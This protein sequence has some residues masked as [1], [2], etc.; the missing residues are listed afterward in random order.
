MTIRL[1]LIESDR[2]IEQKINDAIAKELNKLI[3][4]NSRR[5][6]DRV[7]IAIEGWIT[8]QPEIASLQSEGVVGELNAQ[9][10]LITGQGVLASLDIINAVLA[11]LEVKVRPID[12]RLRGGLDLNIQPVNFRTLL[13]LPSGFVITDSSPLHWL[14]WLLLEGTKTIV[15]G[16]SYNPELSGRSGGGTMEKGGV[17]RIPP[18]YAGSQRDNFITRALA[19]RDKELSS[20]LQDIFK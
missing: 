18:Q 7:K 11:T 9:L 8:S 17:W 4:K 14:N 15:Y 5:A 3:Q 20:I 19:G 16:Y 10:G 1:N 13:D 6:A 12:G 2:Q